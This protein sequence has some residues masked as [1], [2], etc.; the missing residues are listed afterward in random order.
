[1][2]ENILKEFVVSETQFLGKFWF[3]LYIQYIAPI[4]NNNISMLYK[5]SLDLCFKCNYELCAFDTVM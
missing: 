1:M 3:L 5:I 2:T 4:I